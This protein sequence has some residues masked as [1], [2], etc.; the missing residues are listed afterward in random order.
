MDRFTK[1]VMDAQPSFSDVIID[2]FSRKQVEH[3]AE[4]LDTVL[5]TSHKAVRDVKFEYVGYSIMSPE[6]EF[7]TEITTYFG[8]PKSGKINC[9]VTMSSVRRVKY[10]FTYDGEPLWVDMYLPIINKDNTMTISNTKYVL[11]PVLT[12]KI[13][14]P[15]KDHVFIKFYRHKIREEDIVFNLMKMDKVDEVP[16]LH[17]VLIPYCPKLYGI[18]DIKDRLGFGAVTPLALYMLAK[19]TL[20][21]VN[22]KFHS[23]IK[24]LNSDDP[25]ISTLVK[26]GWTAYSSM[27]KQLPEMK[28]VISERHSKVVMAERT[29]SFSETLATSILYM[30]DAMPDMEDQYED[31]VLFWKYALGLMTFKRNI[32]SEGLMVSINDHLIN[33]DTYVDS[34]TRDDIRSMGYTNID[35]TFDFFSFVHILIRDHKI[36][37]KIGLSNSSTV[38]D[39]NLDILYY[40]MFDI[41]SSFNTAFSELNKVFKDKEKKGQ[42][43]THKNVL[44]V[45]QSRS[46][47]TRAIFNISKG[48]NSILPLILANNCCDNKV[49][50][51]TSLV[52]LQSRGNGVKKASN[53]GSSNLPAEATQLKA[54]D[55]YYGNNFHLPKSLAS[56]LARLNPYPRFTNDGR[57]IVPDDL[58]AIIARVQKDLDNIAIKSDEANYADA[59]EMPDDIELI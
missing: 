41:I 36:F 28:M 4:F 46:M 1:A 59:I 49:L 30:F 45:M 53:K 12:D 13:I 8:K 16:A 55:V 48:K 3:T 54:I 17:R 20:S 9:D 44:D 56:P 7:E 34:I 29:D 42:E 10:T 37:K 40:M 5:K 24:V 18:R 19:H 25:E 26:K 51:I 43:I 58:K 27:G 14:S 2:G 6:Q 31:S 50:K 11:M 39:K 21:G 15:Q 47:R 57:I 32:S 33:L 23:N 35:D 38:L 22:K 52:E